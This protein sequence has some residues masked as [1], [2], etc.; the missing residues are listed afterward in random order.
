MREIKF[1]IYIKSL[2]VTVNVDYI[3]FM[4]KE[5]SVEGAA[6]PYV[7]NY[8]EVELMQSTGLKDENG[9]EIYEGD[10]VQFGDNPLYEGVIAECVFLDYRAGF[11]YQF[12]NGQ[13]AG[14]YTDMA[15]T[16]RTYE[17]IGNY[18]ENPELLEAE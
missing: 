16:W 6:E 14:Q 7:Y 17:V 15:D 11:Y 2:K 12:K 3:D 4:N 9:V 10:I 1:R 8:D 5:I 18:L 13:Y